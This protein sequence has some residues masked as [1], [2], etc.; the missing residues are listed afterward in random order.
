AEMTDFFLALMLP[1]AGD[2]LQGIKR[3]LLELVDMMAVNK[4]DGD[5]RTAASRAAGEYATAL[6]TMQPRAGDWVVPVVTCSAQKN[7]GLDEIWRQ[8]LD[9]RQRMQA[10]GVFE[11]KRRR[12]QLRWMWAMVD[13]YLRRKMV[14]HPSVKDILPELEKRVI[15]GEIPPTL[16]AEEIIRAFSQEM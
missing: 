9:H 7:E 13:E 8:V 10:N 12:Q 2:G 4:A 15:E 3:G 14:E 1:N 16:A 5:N 11:K 6:H